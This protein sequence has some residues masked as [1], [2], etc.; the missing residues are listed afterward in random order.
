MNGSALAVVES[1][2][3]S[4]HAGE[5]RD[6]AGVSHAF[7][8]EAEE[9]LVGGRVFSVGELD[10]RESARA[11]MVAESLGAVGACETTRNIRGEL[12][13]KLG[14]NTMT[15]GLAGISGLRSP[16]LWMDPEVAPFVIRLAAEMSTIPPTV[17]N[18]P[19]TKYSPLR[20]KRRCK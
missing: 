3:L 13:A 16:D 9:F 18:K 17:A 14:V 10:G 2:V 12:W 1:D 4:G 6:D 19:R 15:N 20:I 7:V 11:S 8:D 5:A